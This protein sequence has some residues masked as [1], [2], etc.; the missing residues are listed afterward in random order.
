MQS[1]I[2]QIA[3]N[4]GLLIGDTS[5]GRAI[6]QLAVFIGLAGLMT[7]NSASST[8]LVVLSALGIAL[9]IR[10]AWGQPW[11]KSDRTIALLLSILPL[12]YI[13]NMN[14]LG[15]D[16]RALDKPSRLLLAVLAFVALRS[17]PINART[18]F[19]A[20][21][22][23]V[24]I[25]AAIAY[26]QTQIAHL[27]RAYGISHPIPFGNISLI[28]AAIV[29]GGWGLLF[30]REQKK[31]L[32]PW[33][34]LALIAGLWASMASG[35]R[36]G[37]IALP[38]FAYILSLTVPTV[39]TWH[40]TIVLTL[41]TVLM[42]ASYYTVPS[43]QQRIDPAIHETIHYFAS[44]D[45]HNTNLGSFGT[46]L[47]MWRVGLETFRDNPWLGAGFTGFNQSLEM[48]ISQGAINPELRNHA[49]LHN[50]IITTAAKLGILGLGALFIFWLGLWHK[51]RSYLKNANQNPELGFF[52]LIG[53]LTVGGFALFSLSDS[54]FGTFT[55]I[56]AQALLLAIA[57]GGVRTQELS[58][59][60]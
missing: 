33:V 22:L 12:I 42:I 45:T 54:M 39:R 9:L 3:P 40:R 48:G 46:R 55:G 58:P 38:L 6:A 53:L 31:G 35:S 14:L 51:F 28:M 34:V 25:S 30:D 21:L 15:W 59:R 13:L 37:W 1:R 11:D 47:E 43:V 17:L 24:M 18:V 56:H 4:K 7:L 26:Q 23:G 50:E 44:P 41:I 29:L 2:W 10:P 36:G 49:H 60:T 52:A 8:A 57:A 27:P 32:V 5:W 20:S 19:W 16:L